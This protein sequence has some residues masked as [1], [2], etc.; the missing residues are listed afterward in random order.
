MRSVDATLHTMFRAIGVV[1]IIW[2]LSLFFE[3]SFEAFDD[4]A[5]VVF[6]AIET[7]VTAATTNL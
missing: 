4:A 5:T 3:S 7:T 1:I 6:R 2:T